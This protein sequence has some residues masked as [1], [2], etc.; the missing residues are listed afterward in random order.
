MKFEAILDDKKYCKCT[1]V[2]DNVCPVCK[3]RLPF[4]DSPFGAMPS[5]D[6]MRSFYDQVIGDLER[7][8]LE[9]DNF[10]QEEIPRIVEKGEM[11]LAELPR[12]VNERA[13]VL[14]NDLEGMVNQ[15]KQTVLEIEN[16]SRE[17]FVEM[18]QALRESTKKEL[19]T[20]SENTRILEGLIS[21]TI[22]G[23]DDVAAFVDGAVSLI[24]GVTQDFKAAKD[25][26]LEKL[27][28]VMQQISYHLERFSKLAPSTPI[29]GLQ[30]AVLGM[31]PSQY[32]Q[33]NSSMES[34]RS[35]QEKKDQFQKNWNEMLETTAKPQY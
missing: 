34:K 20:I 15:Y 13:A 6:L 19:K 11:K 7:K 28:P 31:E 22:G 9:L 3:K 25:I 8:K 12:L 17:Q 24:F 2:R 14:K 32:F 35:L 33:L 21:K 30:D 1:D 4:V 27:L 5:L 18:D 26:Y 10:F 16:R 29:A 23:L